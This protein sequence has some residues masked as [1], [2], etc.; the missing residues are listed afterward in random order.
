M[1]RTKAKTKKDEKIDFLENALIN[2]TM[3]IKDGP[4]KKRWSQQDLREVK[5]LNESQRILMESYMSGNNIIASGCAG[6]GKSYLAMY[7]ALNDLLSKNTQKNNII[8]VRSAVQTRDVGFLPGTFSEKIEP[9]ELP[10]K[11]ILHN[12]LGK[13]TTYD[14]MKNA[15]YINFMATSLIRGLT[16]DN[17]VIVVDEAQ[18]MTL[19]EI[20]SIVTR[21]GENSTLI[22]CG[23][24]A[25]NDLIYKKNDVSGFADALKIFERIK[26][27]DIVNF[28]ENDIVRSEFVKSWIIA[29]Q[30]K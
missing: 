11:D 18:S 25:Q 17:S 15:G 28:S 26:T 6:T 13:Y 2:N 23:D 9:Y 8:I 27:V 14:D 1:R 22:I 10:Y 19:H 16:W 3:A 29:K 20:D 4:K 5:P 21:V 30:N 12:L 7:L 24:V